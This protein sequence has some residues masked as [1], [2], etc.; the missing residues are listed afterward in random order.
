MRT[1]L[2]FGAATVA[3]LVLQTTVWH[4]LPLG[5]AIPDLLLI[6]CVYLGLHQHTVGGALGAFFLGYAQDSFS[7]GAVGLNAFAMSLV[8][9]LVYLTSRHLWVDNAI[10]KV[11][12]VFLASVVKTMVVVGL[13]AVFLSTAGIWSTLAR[14]LMIEAAV[15]AALSPP[16][17]AMLASTRHV[18]EAE[19]DA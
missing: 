6:L 11:V 18:T 4:W 17:F 7:G 1:V 16:V 14:H 13:I 3:A 9:A 8:F 5:G 2:I 15:A 19:D 10:S 12:L